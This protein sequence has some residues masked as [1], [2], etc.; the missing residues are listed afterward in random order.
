MLRFPRGRCWV[1]LLKFSNRFTACSIYPIELKF[2]CV[3]LNVNPQIRSKLGFSISFQGARLLK[4]LNTFTACDIDPVEL[5]LC[6]MILDIN[7]HYLVEPD[8]SISPHEVL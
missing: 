1:R 3:I 7:P 4:S 8:F 5:H 6:R 2:D